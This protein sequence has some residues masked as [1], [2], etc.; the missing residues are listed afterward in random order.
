MT[1][2]PARLELALRRRGLGR[3]K[4]CEAVGISTRALLAFE[5]GEKRP[6]EST[7]L[8]LA[9]EL[10]FPSTFFFLP[11]PPELAVDAA[12]FRALSTLTLT[13]RNQAL[14]AGALAADLAAW[15]GER[16]DLPNPDVPRLNNIEPERA[17]DYV[18]AAWGMG[19]M[20]APNMIHL[21]ESHGVCV[22]SI[23]D[24]YSDVNAYSLWRN[25]E[26]FIFL[27]T[28]KSGEAGRFDV[29]HELGHLV[30]HGQHEVPRGRDYE[31]QANSFAS[32]LMMPASS[33]AATRLSA[34]TMPQ[35]IQGKKR[36][37]VSA[38][39][40]IVRLH[41]VGRITDWHY[42]T[43]CIQAAQKG[44]RTNEPRGMNRETSQLLGKV[45]SLLRSDGITRHDVATDLGLTV[46]EL[47]RLIFGL[48]HLPVTGEGQDRTE[49][50][51]PDLRLV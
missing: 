2:N 39:A 3:A 30:M 9:R 25:G 10:D 51:R 46:E 34:A 44:Y 14:A 13:K 20:A 17:A 38:M 6:S 49:G 8:C 27:N 23:S 7:I 16:F 1:F 45:F 48:V 43:L 12:S 4:L 35:I 22:F 41:D 33:I 29:A 36:W 37:G 28:K 19:D 18:R 32:A 42:R 11:D 26:P 50:N 21:V 5:K 40:L 47:D 31:H 15:I 24:D